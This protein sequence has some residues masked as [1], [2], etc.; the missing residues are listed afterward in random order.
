MHATRRDS[1]ASV[2]AQPEGTMAKLLVVDDEANLLYSFKKWLESDTLEVAVAQTG[3]EG[4]E[5][6]RQFRPDAVILDVRLTDT[7]GL[8][9][10]D[11]IREFDARLPVIIITAYAATETAIEAMKRGAFEYLL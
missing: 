11:R 5:L 7:S 6:A 10:F 8:E 9:V 4:L 3:R 2:G 1:K